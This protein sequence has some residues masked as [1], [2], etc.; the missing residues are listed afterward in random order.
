M[1][2]RQEL[3]REHQARTLKTRAGREPRIAAI[4]ERRLAGQANETDAVRWRRELADELER[5]ERSLDRVRVLAP[6]VIAG[7]DHRSALRLIQGGLRG[8]R[9]LLGD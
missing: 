5:M 9:R 1:T 8:V 6:R 3:E 4:D 2:G 7:T